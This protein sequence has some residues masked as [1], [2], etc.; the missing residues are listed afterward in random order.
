MIV[1]GE[2]KPEV[3]CCRERLAKYCQGVGLDL[4]FG[5]AK[6]IVDTA[7]TMDRPKGDPLRAKFWPEA[8]LFDW[9]TH[10]E[11]DIARLPWFA[12]NSLD[13]VFSSHA[14][15]DFEDTAAVVAEWLRV[16]KPGGYLVIFCPDQ[17][18]YEVHCK[19][20]GTLPNQS[21]KH[22]DFGLDYLKNVLLT[23]GISE[24]QI[25]HQIPLVDH[26]SFDLVVQKK[27]E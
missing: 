12:D 24:S 10:I 17:K 16:I 22:A 8:P 23:L 26:Y 4:G 25:V 3:D 1:N 21:H 2:L 20:N 15:E 14:L 27:Q 9:M 7:I 5:G 18:A 6:P 13:Y 19:A 11:G